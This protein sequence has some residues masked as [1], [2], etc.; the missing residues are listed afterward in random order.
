[1]ARRL[2]GVSGSSDGS[3]RNVGS[4]LRNGELLVRHINFHW[5]LQTDVVEKFDHI[6]YGAWATVSGPEGSGFTYESQRDDYL[7]ALD[8]VRTPVVDSR[9]SSSAA[10]PASPD[11]S[12]TDPPTTTA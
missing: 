7:I 12:Q 10:E 2:Y 4:V 5:N 9:A 11:A 3:G 8:D 6:T 1:M